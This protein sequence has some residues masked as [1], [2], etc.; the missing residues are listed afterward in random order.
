MPGFCLFRDHVARH[1]E[2]CFGCELNSPRRFTMSRWIVPRFSWISRVLILTAVS[3]AM[4][5]VC[6]WFVWGF[7]YGIGSSVV[8][9]E[10]HY[11]WRYI[12][13]LR[14]MQSGFVMGLVA[15]FLSWQQG[16][17]GLI[18]IHTA[19]VLAG[20]IAGH[21]GWAQGLIGYFGADGLGVFGLALYVITSHR[22]ELKR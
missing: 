17:L 5:L 21:V 4:G 7:I 10:L 1:S 3:G 8:T 15:S 14:G 2:D 6:A 18:A 16:I 19:A 9:D 11:R 13:P 22:L 12:L 20:C